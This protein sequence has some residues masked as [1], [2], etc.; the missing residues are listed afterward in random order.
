[1]SDKDLAIEIK[2]CLDVLK[3][4]GTILYPTDTIW[5]IGCDATNEHAV[6]KIFAIKNR[7]ASKSLITLVS[8][9]AMLNKHVKEVPSMAWDILEYSTK[10]TTIIY[11]AGINVVQNL[12]GEDG[13]IAIRMIKEPFCNKLIHQF[14]KPIVS[15][16]ANVSGQ[17]SPASFFEISDE[18]KNGVDYIVSLRQRE[19]KSIIESTII[20]LNTNGEIVIVRK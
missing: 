7:I 1:M 5:G 9:D 17:P 20:R 16:S 13:S 8:D 2:N 18:I 6:E 3:K 11:P 10:P 14:R 4:G 15:T 19:K 12:L